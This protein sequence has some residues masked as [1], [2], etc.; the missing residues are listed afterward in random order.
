MEREQ[1]FTLIT[2]VQIVQEQQGGKQ[3][4][5][6]SKIRLGRTCS[7]PAVH[8]QGVC[9]EAKEQPGGDE[10]TIED[11]TTTASTPN[12]VRQVSSMATHTNLEQ[13][14]SSKAQLEDDDIVPVA[15]W[16][17]N[18]QVRPSQSS[19]ASQNETTK[20]YWPGTMG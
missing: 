10:G 4:L 7:I 2:M 11:Q 6:N 3:E 15:R 16:L 20:M 17:K 18:S 8:E 12:T 5:Q 19:I 14:G 9:L 13:G 1:F